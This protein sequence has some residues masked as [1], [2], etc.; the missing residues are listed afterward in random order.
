MRLAKLRRKTLRQAQRERSAGRLTS[1]QYTAVLAVCDD[2]KAL[3]ELNERVE[4][5]VNPWNRADGLI[6]LDW[7][8]IWANLWD[9]FVENWPEILKIIMTIAPLLLLEPKREDS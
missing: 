8:S 9:W 2:E 6:G 3:S 7:S 1:E 4:N 5:D